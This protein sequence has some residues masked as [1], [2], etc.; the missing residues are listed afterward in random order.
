MRATRHLHFW[1]LFSGQLRMESFETRDVNR[2]S[3]KY[4]PFHE[5]RK[6][7]TYIP[8]TLGWSNVKGYHGMKSYARAFQNYA[9]CKAA[10]KVATPWEIVQSG[11]YERRRIWSACIYA[12]FSQNLCCSQVRI[13]RYVRLINLR[14]WA[15]GSFSLGWWHVREGTILHAF[16]Q[17]IILLTYSDDESFSCTFNSPSYPESL[18]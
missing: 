11:I 4:F 10:V 9:T 18:S 5:L 16:V 14:T 13:D 15:G 2:K 12:Q 17:H 8:Y 7:Y 1:L 6:K 3:Q